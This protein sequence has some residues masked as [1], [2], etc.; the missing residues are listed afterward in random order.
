MS[1]IQPIR[2]AKSNAEKEKILIEQ[3]LEE[4]RPNDRAIFDLNTP[5]YVKS[6]AEDPKNR[7]FPIQEMSSTFLN[8]RSEI[9]VE[10]KYH[11]NG[12]DVGYSLNRERLKADMLLNLTRTKQER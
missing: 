12:S 4:L 9:K 2:D 7:F 3:L 5:M 11:Y 6:K 8:V 1:K 10:F